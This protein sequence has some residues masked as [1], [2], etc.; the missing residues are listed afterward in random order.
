MRHIKTILIFASLILA[1]CSGDYIPQKKMPEI[2]AEIYKA[3]R[4]INSR[5]NLVLRSDTTR[6]YEAIFNK[7]GY[8]SDDFIKTIDYYLTR[9]VKLKSFYT[10]A[11]AIL[12]KE[13]TIV[14][15]ILYKRERED[16]L[17]AT[18]K[19]LIDES[20]KIVKLKADERAVRW[21]LAPDKYPEIRFATG[22]SLRRLYETP[23][24]SGWWLNNYKKDTLTFPIT[25]RD[26]KNRRPIH[27]PSELEI[28]DIE[29]GSYV[30]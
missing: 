28:A 21:I 2:I 12:E 11:K 23:Q 5:Y 19:K 15:D 10:E 18:Y 30:R 7:Y 8:T 3:D 1:S 9:P 14:A 22:D 17:S 27:L 25:R 13:Q 26:E 29:R 20:G 24:M 6:Y 16:S 4:Y